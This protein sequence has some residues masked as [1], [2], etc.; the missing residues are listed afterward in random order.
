[1]CASETRVL[2]NVL[3][4]EHLPY[5]HAHAFSACDPLESGAGGWRARV[6]LTTP[7]GAPGAEILLALELDRAARRYVA[8]TVEGPGAGTEI[9]TRLAPAGKDATDVAVDFH[10]PGLSEGQR[11]AVGRAYVALY[12]RLWDEDESMMQAREAMLRRRLVGARPRSGGRLALGPAAELAAH[13][14]CALEVDGVPLRIARIGGALVAHSAVCPHW[15]GPLGGD[16]SAPD[17]RLR[18]PWHG[19]AFDARDG[20]LCSGRGAGLPFARA[21]EVD[22]AGVAWLDLEA[23]RRPR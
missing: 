6:R 23:A 11:D 19:F 10:V 8:R 21:I 15:G 14:P 9:W 16:P 2:E 22:D 7:A 3:D 4:F 18:C 5:L 17:V 20:A 13:A 12:Q 1:V